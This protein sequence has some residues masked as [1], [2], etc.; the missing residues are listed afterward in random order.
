[1]STHRSPD[2]PF[3]RE[4]GRSRQFQL[5]F[6]EESDA[7]LL[8]TLTMT[9][10]FGE[11]L[12]GTVVMENRSRAGNRGQMVPYVPVALGLPTNP[13]RK[14]ATPLVADLA[15]GALTA[16]IPLGFAGR[17]REGD[18]LVVHSTAAQHA[19]NL[20]AITGINT[21]STA[22][23]EI[24]F[25]IPVTAAAGFLVS[26]AACVYVAGSFVAT[27]AAD[28]AADATSLTLAN[29]STEGLAVGDE[30]V[31]VA[32]NANAVSVGAVTGLAVGVSTT[33]V[34]FTTAPGTVMATAN[35]A[36]CYVRRPGLVKAEGVL[37]RNREGGEGEFGMPSDI[38]T[39]ICF[40][41]ATLYRAVMGNLDA[42][43]MRD[44]GMKT[45]AEFAWF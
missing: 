36:M 41:K 16:R 39:P 10:G 25:T 19:E 45:R 44:L 26:N 24:S 37:T 2:G 8:P 43:A 13:W 5:F 27:L 35:H 17:F 1:M 14:G 6:S 18:D 40:G 12:T 7:I 32:S 28:C 30:L 11:V 9:P 15:D 42:A 29:E 21:D 38:H 22:F 34:A 23:A 31:V 33:S 3:F 4:T 20:G